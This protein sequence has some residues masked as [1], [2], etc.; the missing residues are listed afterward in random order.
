M[1]VI[2]NLCSRK[3]NKNNKAPITL[4][5]SAGVSGGGGTTIEI[6]GTNV[7]GLHAHRHSNSG[8]LIV[9]ERCAGKLGVIVLN[10]H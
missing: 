7:V 10:G 3:A 5:S 8:P 1:F 6:N 9:F 4:D 2:N